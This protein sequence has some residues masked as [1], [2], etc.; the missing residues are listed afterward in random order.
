[1]S[2][3]LKQPKGKIHHLCILDFFVHSVSP[4]PVKSKFSLEYVLHQYVVFLFYEIWSLNGSIS[5]F[6]VVFVY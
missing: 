6:V 1:M 5:S 3:R 4:G 2:K